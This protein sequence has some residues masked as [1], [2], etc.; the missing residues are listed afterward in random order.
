[1]TTID[2]Q[3]VARRHGQAP[4]TALSGA[5][6][7]RVFF[8]GLLVAATLGAGLFAGASPALS[9]EAVEAPATV[10]INTADA[11]TLAAVLKGVGESRAL[12]IVRH[13]Q[14]YGAFSTVDELMEVKGIG[15]ATL[16]LNRKAIT[17]E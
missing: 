9:A 7:W 17:L 8:A 11:A 16:D 10:N 15:R 1:M 12:E 14:M 4:S 2:P 13:R 6:R 5:F 3:P